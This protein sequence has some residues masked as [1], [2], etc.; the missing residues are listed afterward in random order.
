M[1]E[2]FNWEYQEQN[3][4]IAMWK[5]QKQC[6]SPFNV[7]FFSSDFTPHPTPGAFLNL[8]IHL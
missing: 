7:E 2:R 6:N 8:N 4:E 3:D 5:D 1:S